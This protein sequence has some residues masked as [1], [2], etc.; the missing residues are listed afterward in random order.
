[1]KTCFVLMR[2]VTMKDGSNASF[3]V[4]VFGSQTDARVEGDRAVSQF[5]GMH[6]AVHAA[7]KFLGIAQ[8]GHH[9]LEVPHVDGANIIIAGAGDMP[10]PPRLAPR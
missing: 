7:I 1:M 2:V 8:V 3:A 4:G 9:V 6:P 10:G 5:Q